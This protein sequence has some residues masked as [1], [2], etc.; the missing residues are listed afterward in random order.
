M[1]ADGSLLGSELSHATRIEILGKICFIA[2][3]EQNQRYRLT[4][5]HFMRSL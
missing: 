5:I 2:E 4:G 1:M 3:S